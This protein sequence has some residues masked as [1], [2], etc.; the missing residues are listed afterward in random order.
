MSVIPIYRNRFSRCE[1]KEGA[2]V[3]TFEDAASARVFLKWG[4]N[5]SRTFEGKVAYKTEKTRISFT[6]AMG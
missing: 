3:F 1:T 6:T 2:A 4:S 5:P